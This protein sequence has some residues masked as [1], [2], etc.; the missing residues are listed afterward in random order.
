MKYPPSTPE[1]IANRVRY[2]REKGAEW[3]ATTDR[4]D[5]LERLY[6]L[7]EEEAEEGFSEGKKVVMNN[8][9]QR[10]TIDCIESK[11]GLN[12]LDRTGN[13]VCN[14]EAF[15]EAALESYLPRREK[16]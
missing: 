14:M 6:L 5:L 7:R 9:L 13:G 16:V 4:T 1:Q 10:Q 2:G 3:G 11:Y 8:Y 15:A 12:D